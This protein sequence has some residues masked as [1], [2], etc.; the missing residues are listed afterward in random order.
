VLV[1]HHIKTFSSVSRLQRL[2]DRRGITHLEAVIMGNSYGM[3]D[4]H[5]LVGRVKHL[6]SFNNFYY[7]GE[8]NEQMERAIKLSFGNNMDVANYLEDKRLPLKTIDCKFYN[9]GHAIYCQVNGTKTLTFSAFN[10]NPN[11]LDID[12]KPDIV[13]AYDYEEM[14]FSQYNATSKISFCG[15]AGYKNAYLNGNLIIPV[16]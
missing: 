11:Y 7:F 2:L 16:S 12:V 3:T 6:V 10:S 5:T 8:I 9:N 4:G 15:S 14:I 1:V 13:V